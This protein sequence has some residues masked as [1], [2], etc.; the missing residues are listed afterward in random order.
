MKAKLVAILVI[1]IS[2]ALGV[3]IPVKAATTITQIN[4]D[5]EDSSLHI[6]GNYLVWQGY[7]QLPGATSGAADWEIFLYDVE[8]KDILQITD[9]DYDDVSPWTDANHVVWRG[10]NRTGGEIFV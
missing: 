8:T 4:T 1:V 9:N 2:V 3:S 5:F 6:E 10:Y 7:G